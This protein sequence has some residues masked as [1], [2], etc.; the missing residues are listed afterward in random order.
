MMKIRNGFVTNSSSSSFIL[1]FKDANDVERNLESTY[2]DE[3]PIHRD[4]LRSE[5]FGDCRKTY[6]EIV[7]IIEKDECYGVYDWD[8]IHKYK[9]I[10][11]KENPEI[12]DWN[13]YLAAEK[14]ERYLAELNAIQKN[15]L[16]KINSRLEGKTIFA[17]VEHGDGGNGED[18][19]LEHEILPYLECTVKRFSHHWWLRRIIMR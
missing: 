10:I 14:D 19:I 2:F 1:A 4:E 13:L 5:I 12:D 11:K 7:E 3:Y 9:K 17:Y 6:D 18:G 15:A 16:D 8:L